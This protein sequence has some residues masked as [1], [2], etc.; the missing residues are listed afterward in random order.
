MICMET[1]FEKSGGTVYDL[2]TPKGSWIGTCKTLNKAKIRAKRH[3]EKKPYLEH[4]NILKFMGT[5]KRSK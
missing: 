2:E 1:K 5:V 3:L 4:I